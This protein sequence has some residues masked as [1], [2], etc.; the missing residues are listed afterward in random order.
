MQGVRA[1]RTWF[2]SWCDRAMENTVG[3]DIRNDVIHD[4]LVHTANR[5]VLYT[6][7][8]DNVVET[9][10]APYFENKIQWHPWF[11]TIAGFRYDLID[12]D[13]KNNFTYFTN[14]PNPANSGDRFDYAPEPKLSL[15]FGP[16]AKTEFYLNGGLGFHTD[17]ARGVNTTQDPL[18]GSRV[19]RALPIARTQG[20]EIGVR[21]LAIPNLQ[22]TLTFW[23]LDWTPNWYGTGMRVRPFPARPPISARVWNGQTSIRRPSG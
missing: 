15:I 22:S 23:A 10:V 9:D 8:D 3:L 1:N 4:G 21:T 16:W 12:F 17:D 11:R 20:A 5:T 6:I 14:G 7:R 18:D 13:N 2:G 19:D